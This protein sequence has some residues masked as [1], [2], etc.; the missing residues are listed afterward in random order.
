MSLPWKTILSNVPWSDVLGKAPIIA[1]SA[2]KLWKGMGRKNGDGTSAEQEISVPP[3]ADLA[4]RFAA[5]EASQRKQRTQILAAGELIQ[6]LSE[7][8]AQLAGQLDTLRR[9]TRRQTW[10]LAVTALTAGL[11]LVLAAQ[12]KLLEFLA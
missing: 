4:T 1:D 7:Q 3:D 5:L 11:A 6:A 12:P 10:I 2:K 8:N 9:R